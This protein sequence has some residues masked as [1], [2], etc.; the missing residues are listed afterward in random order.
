MMVG[1][2]ALVL[3]GLCGLSLTLHDSS[4]VVLVSFFGVGAASQAFVVPQ[5]HRLFEVRPHLALVSSS[6]NST[7]LYGGIALAPVLGGSVIDEG[8]AALAGLG[9]AAAA[10]ALVLFA[11]G[12]RRPCQ[13]ARARTA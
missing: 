7:A 13:P 5:Q 9:A 10:A 12:A 11:L 8:G 1:T 4:A 6:W 3:L 2:G